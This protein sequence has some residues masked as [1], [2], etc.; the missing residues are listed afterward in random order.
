MSTISWRVSVAR[1][2][3]RVL[4]RVRAVWHTGTDEA[5]GKTWPAREEF[6]WLTPPPRV[7]VPQP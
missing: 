6:P 5:A 1:W 4:L 7:D 3:T 2:P